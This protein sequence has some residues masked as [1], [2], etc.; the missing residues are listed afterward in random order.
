MPGSPSG[1]NPGGAAGREGWGGG[2]AAGCSWLRSQGCHDQ[3]ELFDIPAPD[4]FPAAASSEGLAGA[5]TGPV[6]GLGGRF[7]GSAGLGQPGLG[8]SRGE[9]ERGWAGQEAPLLRC[10]A[11]SLLLAAPGASAGTECL[12]LCPWDGTLAG[13]LGPAPRP[14]LPTLPGPACRW[15]FPKRKGAPAC[16]EPSRMA[17]WQ[18]R[19]GHFR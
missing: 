14:L 10:S 4:A 13:S 9:A 18:P 19:K 17:V 16:T 8:W 11:A 7:P 3:R 15:G 2:A 12:G 6:R 5:G 1:L